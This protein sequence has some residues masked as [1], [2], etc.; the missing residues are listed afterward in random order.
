MLMEKPSSEKRIEQVIVIVA[1]HETSLLLYL[2]TSQPNFCKVSKTFP[3]KNSL[4]KPLK[5]K[6]THHLGDIIHTGDGDRSVKVPWCAPR[7]SA[8]GKL[9]DHF[10]LLGWL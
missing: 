8:T 7:I 5:P 9:M 3:S 10:Q 1:A 4:L 2:P 6:C